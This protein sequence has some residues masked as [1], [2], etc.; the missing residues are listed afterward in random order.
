MDRDGDA[1]WRFLLRPPGGEGSVAVLLPRR[2]IPM[3][4][5]AAY[6]EPD[7]VRG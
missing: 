3:P 7:D 6:A 1:T 4:D 2:G 5:W